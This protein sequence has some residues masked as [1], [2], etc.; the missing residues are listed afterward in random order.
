MILFHWFMLMLE[1]IIEGMSPFLG[2]ISGW[3]TVLLSFCFEFEYHAV[4]NLWRKYQNFKK[5]MKHLLSGTDA[6]RNYMKI[7]KIYFRNTKYQDW[8]SLL[9]L[10]VLTIK[11]KS[12][13]YIFHCWEKKEE[14][15]SYLNPLLL[16]SV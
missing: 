15:F 9:V 5:L 16:Y 12:L 14:K 4:Q 7:R 10:N 11:K 6:L 3:N 2:E 1:E 13:L 8:L